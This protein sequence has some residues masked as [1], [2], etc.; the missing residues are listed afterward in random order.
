MSTEDA[1]NTA[2]RISL[3]NPEV[4]P[5][6]PWTNQDGLV[7]LLKECREED[8]TLLVKEL[9]T[10]LNENIVDD[11]KTND[12]LFKMAEA[13]NRNEV[14]GDKTA[15][16]VMRV[17]GDPKSDGSQSILDLLKVPLDIKVNFKYGYCTT[18]F[19]EIQSLYQ[20]KNYRHFIVVDDF[21]GSGKT[22]FRRYWQFLNW[23]LADATI[24]FYFLAGMAK[25]MSFCRNWTIPADC[26]KIMYKGISGHYQGEDL[27][28]RVWAMERLENQLS[29]KS[30]DVNLKDCEF[31]YNHAEALFCRKY[32][33]IPNS[34]FPI[35]WWNKYDNG[36]KRIPIFRRIQ[37]G[38]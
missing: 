14:A 33:N 16:A 36:D 12:L 4:F 18:T 26:C 7:S 32:G 24:H 23:N 17:K 1:F 34:V 3:E 37:D 9:I 11:G 35:F 13:I 6:S 10:Q 15:L 25:A 27:L 31:G 30:G 29:S 38:F 21:I 8:D 5:S 28:K 2:L 22:V 19:N 20:K